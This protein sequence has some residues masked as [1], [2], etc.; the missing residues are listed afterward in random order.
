MLSWLTFLACNKSRHQYHDDSAT[1]KS[2]PEEDDRTV[3]YRN[4]LL[5]IKN[6]RCISISKISNSLHI[7]FQTAAEI[8]QKIEENG[9]IDPALWLSKK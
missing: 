4:V 3:L 1:F 7:D 5:L 9:D 8:V 2:E 6:N